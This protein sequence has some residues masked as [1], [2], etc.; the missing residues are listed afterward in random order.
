MIL[1]EKYRTLLRRIVMD[2]LLKKGFTLIELLVASG[3]MVIITG[4][5]VASYNNFS[6]RQEVKNAAKEFAGNV[7]FIGSKA[8]TNE[9]ICKD[10]P[11]CKGTDGKCND[12]PSDPSTDDE[13]L[14]GW[15]LSWQDDNTYWLFGTCNTSD[16][17]NSLAYEAD[18]FRKKVISLSEKG[19]T[20][21]TFN[22]NPIIFYPL[23]VANSQG[24]T[25]IPLSGATVEIS[26][27][28]VY[29]VKVHISSSGD[30]KVED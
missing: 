21:S 28:G 7:R 22:P 18:R 8:L 2:N 15:Y 6:Q 11:F 12:P 24:A 23:G 3:I 9:K 4:L 13:P 5:G 27:T 25:N 26:K 30:V 16:D 1:F 14:Y 20:L 29:T 19:I 17:G 10:S